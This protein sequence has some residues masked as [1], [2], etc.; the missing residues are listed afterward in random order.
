VNSAARLCDL[1]KGVPGKVLVSWESVSLAGADEQ[2]HWQPDSDH[3]LRGRAE[4]TATG[5]LR[6]V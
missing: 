3:V 6:C 2:A 4:A 1:A 5:R